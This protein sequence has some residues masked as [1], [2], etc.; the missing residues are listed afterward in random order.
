MVPRLRFVYLIGGRPFL[1]H[2]NHV[3]IGCQDAI[4]GDGILMIDWSCLGGEHNFCA[5]E[6]LIPSQDDINNFS[7]EEI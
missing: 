5:L 3:S 6:S 2:I 1:A 7:C 4:G